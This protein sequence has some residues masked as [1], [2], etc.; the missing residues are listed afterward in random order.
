MKNQFIKSAVTVALL[1]SLIVFSCKKKEATPEDTSTPTTTGS[2]TTTG[3]AGSFMWQENG[4]AAISAD[5]A[6]WTTGTWGTGVRA[7]KGGMNNF[8]EINWQ[9]Q[10]AITV[11]TQTLG[12]FDGVTFKKGST[13]FN[14]T[15]GQSISITASSTS[16]ISGNFNAPVN[17]GTNTTVSS[18]TGT[19]TGLNKK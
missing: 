5:S 16:T 15:S 4:G 7:Y 14:G 12:A 3:G 1:T 6:F 2:S 17:G 19:F 13:Y 9:G 8:F 11:G 10:N 18:V